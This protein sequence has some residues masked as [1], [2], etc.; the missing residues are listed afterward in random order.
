MWWAHI[1][2]HRKDHWIEITVVWFDCSNHSGM[3]ASNLLALPTTILEQIQ[4]ENKKSDWKKETDRMASRQLTDTY[5][6]FISKLHRKHCRILAGPLT[7]HINLQYILH[8]VG[9][10]KNTSC[11]RCDAE[12]KILAHIPCQ[13]P[14]LEKVRMQT[15]GIA[16]MD[17]E[18]IKVTRL[19]GIVALGKGAGLINS[20]YE[21]KWEGYGNVASGPES[22][23][24]NGN[25]PRKKNRL[26]FLAFTVF[27]SQKCIKVLVCFQHFSIFKVL[28][29]N[30]TS[31]IPK[32]YTKTYWQTMLLWILQVRV[33]CFHHWL[34]F[35]WWGK[36]ADPSLTASY[37]VI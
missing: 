15:L 36:M 4:V 35:C 19:N 34:S 24:P 5:V 16:R 31:G 28:F 29:V 27:S 2:D 18:Q 9:R 23:V 26:V 11:R 12:K 32:D 21:F 10:A 13:C 8:K 17:V 6:Q 20:P 7:G 3:D 1:A 30:C 22:W 37:D 25:P 33:R 14:V